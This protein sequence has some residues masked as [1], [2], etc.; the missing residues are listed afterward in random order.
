MRHLRTLAKDGRLD[1]PD[2]SSATR[3]F[4]ALVTSETT[5]TQH[6]YGPRTGEAK[7]RRLI[8]AAVHAFLHGYGRRPS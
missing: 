5:R 1:V 7:R 2:P 3:H 6:P 8:E 4:I